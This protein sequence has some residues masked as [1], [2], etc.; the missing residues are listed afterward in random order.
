MTRGVPSRSIGLITS[1]FCTGFFMTVGQ[2]NPAW[3]EDEGKAFD[4]SFLYKADISGA[5]SGGVSKAGRFL[6]NIDLVG[7]ASLEKLWGWNG[8]RVHGHVLSNSGGAPNDVA[9]TL[10]GVDNIEVARPRAKLYELWLEQDFAGGRGSVLTGLYDLNSEFY[11]TEA[12]G[13]LIAPAF[14]IGSELAATGPNGPSIFPST[15]L[16]MRARWNISEGQRIQG[17]VLNASAGVV[18][19]PGGVDLSFDDGALMIAEWARTGDMQVRLGAWRYTNSQDDIREL[20]PLGVP[21]QRTA[22]GLYA[23][24]EGPLWK[25]G[26]RSVSGFVRAGAADG[27]TTS[28]QGGW[29]AGLL[30]S[31]VFTGRPDSAFSVGVNQGL[32]NSGER[33]NARDAG[34]NPASA[35]SAIELTYA[36][37]LGDKLTLQPDLQLVHNPGAD[38]DRETAVIATLRLQVEF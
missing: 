32:T 22:Q 4:W 7:D 25:A 11:Q 30:A 8:A 27:H 9:G 38:A 23:S 24:V 37:K 12:A 31:P 15:A 6:D 26:E 5:L 29:Q 3:A 34:L 21:R 20:D 17:A 16:A 18:G 19:D 2:A 33:A 35:E 10:Q 28:Y 1:I 13:L 36:D 14:G